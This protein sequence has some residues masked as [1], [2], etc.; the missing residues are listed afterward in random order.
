MLSVS[1][2]YCSPVPQI[3]NGFA[4]SATNV[5]YGGVAKYQCYQGFSFASGKPTE[6]IFCQDDGRWTAPP[7][8]KGNHSFLSCWLYLKCVALVL[9]QTCPALPPF[10]NGKKTLL[11]GDGTGYGT[12]YHYECSPG[13]YRI[14]VPSLLCQ[15]DGL[16]SDE[17][18]YC[19]SKIF[20]AEG[21]EVIFQSLSIFRVALQ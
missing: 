4:V 13:Y 21:F 9:A 17:Q 3:P 12:I 15:T 11:F 8:C 10:T 16:W 5:T 2:R 14:G 7:I 1:A 19:K 20:D 18:P 6:E